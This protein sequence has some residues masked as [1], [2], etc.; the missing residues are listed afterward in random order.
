MN[1]KLLTL[2]L[3]L[4][5]LLLGS[6]E[7]RV[8]YADLLDTETRSV[9][10]YL[11]QYPMVLDL[12]ADTSQFITRDKIMVEKGI[13]STKEA[14][15]LTPFYRMDNEGQVYMQIISN[16]GEEKAKADQ[17]VFFRFTRYNINIWANSGVLTSAG[18]NEADLG[19]TPT[20][21]RYQNT[22]LTSST[23]WGT[24]IQVPLDYLGLYSEVNLIVKSAQ[25]PSQEL[26]S[27]Y[28]YLYHIRYFKSQI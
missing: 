11:A 13:T 23:Q 20:S 21:F 9:N 12:P 25:G 14:L 19:S 6:C 26:S 4:P 1:N 22:T 27:V 18:G 10:S 7:D 17:E 2:L 15:A 16:P 3:P 5:A 24:G 8:T 28:P